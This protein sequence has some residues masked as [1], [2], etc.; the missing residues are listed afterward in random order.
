MSIM[1]NLKSSLLLQELQQQNTALLAEISYLKQ[2]LA[3]L[4]RFIFGQKRERFISESS[5][6]QLGLA[7]GDTA[8]ELESRLEQI[9]YERKKVTAKPTP[10]GR[11]EL[12]AHLERRE[13]VIEPEEDVNGF[14]KIGEEITE[15]LDYEPGHLYV[16]RY[17]RPKYSR[18]DKDGVV[19]GLLPSRP[20]EKGIAGAGL[21]SHIM[22]SKYVDHLPVYR[23]IQQF[24]RQDIKL[25]KSTVDDW[26]RS[27]CDLLEPLY[28]VH[29]QYL[30]QTDYLMI[31]ETTIRVLDKH[32]KGKSHQGYFWVYYDPIAKRVLFDYR[33]GRGREGP[34]SMLKDFTGTIQT[35][36]YGG[37]EQLAAR[38]DITAIGCMAH[39]R[40]YF[41][42]AL[43]QDEG[44]AEGMLKQIQILYKI[45]KQSREQGMSYQQR[46]ALRLQ[47]SQPILDAMKDWLDDNLTEVLPKSLIGKAITYMLGRWQ[48]LVGYLEDGRYE[49]DNNLVENAI[50]PVALGRKNYLFA[51][52]HNGADWAALI[53]SLVA[54]AK[55]QGVEP[56]GYLKEILTILPDWPH[57]N[58][59]QLLP[60]NWKNHIS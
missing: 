36:G 37:Y 52:S 41:K 3:N 46:H 20:I 19:I 16:N 53:Y 33:E 1:D 42:D 38:A 17:I 57:K 58:I 51:G 21:L 31:D 18:S 5:P 13:I 10:H 59:D 28:A 43:D 7:L 4:R 8:V 11:G 47:E 45:E 25:A 30:L 22:I 27:C 40:R 6:D 9:S 35:D 24:K 14:S 54:T 12:P 32:K 29:K 39:A 34:D 50:R 23:Q 2:E 60:Q 26:L 56:F 48:A 49:I 55:L 44:R 15:E